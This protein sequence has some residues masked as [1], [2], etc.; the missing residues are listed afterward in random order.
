M[1][2]VENTPINDVSMSKVEDAEINDVSKVEENTVECKDVSHADDIST[3][4]ADLANIEETETEIYDSNTFAHA[5][6]TTILGDDDPKTLSEF[7]LSQLAFVQRINTQIVNKHIAEIPN[8]EL[9]EFYH[10]KYA[11]HNRVTLLR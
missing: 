5:V 8:Y 4:E 3:K 2:Q 9:M 10:L 11:C 7:Y 1:S 6:V